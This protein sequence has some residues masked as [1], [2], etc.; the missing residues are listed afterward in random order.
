M[1]HREIIKLLETDGWIAEA[2]GLYLEEMRNSG[3]PVSASPIRYELL[4][5]AS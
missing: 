3:Q 2:I 4:E 5:I 1:K